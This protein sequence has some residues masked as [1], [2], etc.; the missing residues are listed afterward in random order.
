MRPNVR[1]LDG[2]LIIQ[3]AW[4]NAREAFDHPEVLCEM[5]VRTTLGP[6]ARCEQIGLVAEI[7]GLDHERVAL[8]V[9]ARFSSKLAYRRFG[10]GIGVERNDTYVVDVLLKNDHVL[11][12]LKKVIVV[13]VGGR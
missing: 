2:K 12:S 13:V 5:P 8:P 11:G 6:R 10:L 1:I 3:R 4:A 7:G 9:S